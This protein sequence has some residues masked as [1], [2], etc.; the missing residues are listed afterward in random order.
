MSGKARRVG[1]GQRLQRVVAEER[2]LAD[3]PPI[4]YLNAKAPSAMF[5][6][7]TTNGVPHRAIGCLNNGPQPF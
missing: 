5:S 7:L 2:R 6:G 3:L 4:S 1:R